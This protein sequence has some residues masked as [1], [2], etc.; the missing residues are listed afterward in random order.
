[1]PRRGQPVTT[2]SG[3]GVIINVFPFKETVVVEFES[4]ASA[5]FPLS[6]I[7][8][9]EVARPRPVESTGAVNTAEEATP[10]PATETKVEEV[11]VEELIEVETDLLI[12]PEVEPGAYSPMIIPDN[13]TPAV[14]P[15]AP[16]PDQ[17][18]A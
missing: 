18:A 13:A 17:P 15:T 9:T 16:P 1:M 11:E 8:L 7:K 5:E 6:Q 3:P 4:Q 2:P 10:A 12:V 14:H